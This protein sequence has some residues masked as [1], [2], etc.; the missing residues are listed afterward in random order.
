LHL[1]YTYV[2]VFVLEYYIL[3]ENK[4]CVDCV[5]RLTVWCVFSDT[6]VCCEPVF[7]VS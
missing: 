5:L 7:Q 2:G 6:S 3:C 1:F 4:L